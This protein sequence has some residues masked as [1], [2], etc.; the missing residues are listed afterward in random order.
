MA[1]VWRSPVF[2]LL[3]G[4]GFVYDR[5]AER[6]ASGDWLGRSVFYQSPLYP[7]FM[8][9]LYAIFGHAPGVVRVAQA[10]LSSAACAALARAGGLFA[11]RF[12]GKWA[13]VLLALYGPALFFDAIIQKASL[14]LFLTC[15][16][17]WTVAEAWVEGKPRW[18]F[19]AGVAC[20]LLA[21]NRE[22][23][24]LLVPLIP[25]GF[26]IFDRERAIPRMR[27]ASWCLLGSA[28]VLLPVGAR[29][30]VVG[31]EFHLTTSQF[32][33]NFYI[34]NRPGADGLYH[35]LRTGRGSA[36]LEQTD[37]TELAEQAL[38][39]KLGPR[40]VSDF[41]T[42]QT[43]RGIE[44]QPGAWAKLMLRK[45]V[46]VWNAREIPDSEDPILY[47]E[48]SWILRS[49]S[50]VWNFA[51]LAP[52]AAAGL[53]ATWNWRRL[54][55]VYVML[56]GL[57]F[58]LALF[59]LFARYRFPLVP[60]LLVGAAVL[61]AALREFN[62]NWKRLAGPIA[63]FALMAAVA[64]APLAK[65]EHPA[66]LAHFNLGVTLAGRGRNAEAE[67]EYRKALA[68]MPAWFPARVNLAKVLAD[69][70][71]GDEALAEYEKVLKA[72]PKNA[73]AHVNVGNLLLARGKAAEAREHFAAALRAEPGMPEAQAGLRAADQAMPHEKSR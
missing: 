42:E 56:A 31:G 39:R 68:E 17:L 16:T 29:N 37:A 58:S 3:V 18:S 9:V 73:Y 62:G 63:A 72:Q 55:P 14:D 38:G 43:I 19:A 20:G 13:G 12:G 54:W 11:P 21:L 26:A 15:A 22:N 1:Q 34:G 32:G 49:L 30:A 33:P 70:G 61:P 66:V 4:D 10:I 24:L 6:I 5:W 65:V 23:A 53:F 69:Q 51:V 71:R 25:A 59:F 2:E 57:W 47:R 50:T 7:Y 8:A 36:L 67:A 44:K 41:W 46:L 27:M 60:P 52:L 35:P 45:A 48:R 40:E 28:C 64:A